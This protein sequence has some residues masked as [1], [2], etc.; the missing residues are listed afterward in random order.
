MRVLASS[1]ACVLLLLVGC[2]KD[3]A[4]SIELRRDGEQLLQ[5]ESATVS[6]L[7][8]KPGGWAY[9]CQGGGS[10]YVIYETDEGPAKGDPSKMASLRPAP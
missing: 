3:Q 1:L 6:E 10:V 7:T 5:C 4:V 9:K 2:A 8:P